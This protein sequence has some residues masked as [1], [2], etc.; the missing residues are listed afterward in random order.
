VSL[1][2]LVLLSPLFAVIAAGI[3]LT[4][5]GPVFYRGE[6]L[7]R[8]GRVFT[9]YKFRTLRPGAEQE[10]GAR[11]L[12]REERATHAT[13]FGRFLKRSKV[14]EMP[15]LI[16]VIRGDMR[17]VGPRPIRPIFLETLR[18]DPARF[19]AL[20]SVPPGLTG[21][22]QV[23]GGYYTSPRAKLRYGL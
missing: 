21:I 15:Q 1:I 14:D 20:L 11:L 18:L 3:K 17:L 10:I 19:E 9:I 4:S 6:R 23:R 7:G 5:E 13:Q 22:A 2:A 16:N 8:G 12:R